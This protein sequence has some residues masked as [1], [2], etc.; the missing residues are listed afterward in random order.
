MEKDL[1]RTLLFYAEMLQ[2]KQDVEQ[3]QEN[4]YKM[5]LTWDYY[6]KAIDKA[7]EILND[8]N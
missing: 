5:S 7:R 4:Y 6:H 1:I 2:N 3:F 8:E